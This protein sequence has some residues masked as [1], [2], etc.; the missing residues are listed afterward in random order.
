M[1]ALCWNVGPY[2]SRAYCIFTLIINQ[3]QCCRLVIQQLGNSNIL[4]AGFHSGEFSFGSDRTVK[5][6]LSV[7]SQAELMPFTQR[8]L[9]YPSQ[10][11]GE[12]S[13]VETSLNWLSPPSCSTN[14]GTIRISA[15][16]QGMVPTNGRTSS[17]ELIIIRNFSKAPSVCTKYGLGRNLRRARKPLP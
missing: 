15:K 7:S 14:C 17:W 2:S 8:K 16:L 5:S 13:W 6:P 11:W 12:L 10:S 1:F 9:S 3:Y 4:K